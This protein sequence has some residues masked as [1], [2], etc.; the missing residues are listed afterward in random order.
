MRESEIL[1]EKEKKK[2]THWIWYAENEN[3]YRENLSGK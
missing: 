2:D 1:V 3:E